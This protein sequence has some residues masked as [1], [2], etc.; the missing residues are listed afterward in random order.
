MRYF[1]YIKLALLFLIFGSIIWIQVANNYD[2]SHFF[3]DV[4]GFIDKGDRNTAEQ[5]H[6]LCVR[7]N[8]IEQEHGLEPVDC[9]EEYLK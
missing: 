4:R 7:L 2:H 8:A 9:D 5:G 6:A 3:D 1:D